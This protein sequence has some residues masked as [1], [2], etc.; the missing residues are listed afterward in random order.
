MSSYY[1]RTLT[2]RANNLGTDATFMLIFDK[3][4]E[5]LY[6]KFPVVWKVARFGAS[7]PYHRTVTFSS[8]SLNTG[9]QPVLRAYITSAYT[10]GQIVEDQ[11]PTPFIF[12]QNLSYLDNITV[13]D[14]KYD[15]PTGRFSIVRA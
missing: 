7:G 13:W 10:E 9:F 4:S 15:F 8:Q 6:D 5:G 11:I 1:T 2:F 12:E 3:A 14:L